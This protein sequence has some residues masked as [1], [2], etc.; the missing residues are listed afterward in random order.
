MNE[1]Q[2]ASDSDPG[3]IA[4][5]VAR[6]SA[7]GV[8]GGPG[9]DGSRPMME[10]ER[11][12]DVLLRLAKAAGQVQGVSR[13]VTTDR[14]CVDVLTQIAA[15]QKAL[16]GVAPIITRNY[17]SAHY[18]A[19]PAPLTSVLPTADTPMSVSTEWTPV[20]ATG[21]YKPRST[22][23]VRNRPNEGTY[24]YEVL[25]PLHLKDGAV[26]LVDRG[27]VPNAPAAA[28]RPDVPQAPHGTVTVTGWLRQ[29]E[30]N[31]GRDN[32]DGQLASINLGQAQRRIDGDLFGALRDH[33]GR[34][35]DDA[36]A[37]A[38]TGTARG[39]RHRPGAQPRL[40]PSVV[41]RVHRRLRPRLH[42]HPPAEG[43]GRLAA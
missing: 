42:G 36:T 9:C 2:S 26:L 39:T 5:P 24:G 38:A 33:E 28:I 31:L 8:S 37:G 22:Q 7:A 15:A 21:R 12:D 23:L 25:V 17:L 10:P 40:R 41:G 4:A 19:K 43:G 30:P 20:T 6:R 34:G 3:P 29:G 35:P 18:Q 32:P 11:R 14:Y 1:D 13:M 16:D 27:W